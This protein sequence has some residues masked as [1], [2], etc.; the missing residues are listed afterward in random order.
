MRGGA[1]IAVGGADASHG[2]ALPSICVRQRRTMV[3]KVRA[4]PS[5]AGLAKKS[6]PL[7]FV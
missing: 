1:R 2:F 3:G 7:T 6:N 5:G 4:T